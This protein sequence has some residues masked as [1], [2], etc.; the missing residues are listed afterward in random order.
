MVSHSRNSKPNAQGAIAILL[1]FLIFVAILVVG[2]FIRTA[3]KDKS[4]IG[5]IFEE[6][7]TVPITLTF[8]GDVMFDRGVRSSIVKNFAGDYGALFANASYLKEADITFAN[9]EGTVSTDISP[10]TGSRFSFRM[11]PQGLVAMREAGF[12]IVSFA[13][14]HVGDYSTKGF[15][16]T[17]A[18]LEEVGILFSGAGR[19][20]ADVVTPTVIDVRGTKIGFLAATDVGPDWLRAT[21]TDPGILLASDPDLSG[22]I[23]RAKAQV[24]ILVVSFHF[25]NEYSPVNARQ[26]KIARAAVDAGADIVVGH[27][28]HVMESV[29]EYNGGVIFYSL[30]NFIFDQYFSEHTMRGM[31]VNVSIDPDTNEMSHAISVS[32]I[33]RQYIPQALVPFDTSMLVTKTFTP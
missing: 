16:A 18:N 25:G 24:D 9:L 4:T 26:Q 6:E 12:D 7:K 20:K 30:G 15:L 13:N 2:A 11:D 31:V 19:Q 8:V 14:N 32:P 29:E 3:S 5:D 28:P 10:R 27:H 33:S 22:I 21:D 17:L 23:T 1:L